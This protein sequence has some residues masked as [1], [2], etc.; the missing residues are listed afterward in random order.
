MLRLVHPVNHRVPGLLHRFKYDCSLISFSA[1]WPVNSF[2]ISAK[3]LFYAV[4]VFNFFDFWLCSYSFQFFQN[5]LVMQLQFFLPELFCRSILWKGTHGL[6]L[7]WR[8]IAGTLASVTLSGPVDSA[9]CII[10]SYGSRRD[11]RI[12][13]PNQRN[14]GLNPG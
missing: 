10:V 7:S 2:L 13:V 8:T 1:S 11:I 4:T 5:Y 3:Y 12:D 14:Q 9:E 6:K